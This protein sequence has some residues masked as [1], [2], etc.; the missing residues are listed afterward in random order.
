[1]N[2]S[3]SDFGTLPAP[4][5][6]VR[7]IEHKD[8]EISVKTVQVGHQGEVKTEFRYTT[9]G[10]EFTAK[11]AFGEIKGTAKWGGDTLVVETKRSVQGA[12]IKQVDRWTISEDGKA[13]NV[14]SVIQTPNGAFKMSLN[15]D[16]Q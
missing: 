5:K 15:F 7:T 13:L 8:P 6:L 10:R 12:E 9:D 3:K 14:N 4:E 1:M 16:K 11:S 2:A